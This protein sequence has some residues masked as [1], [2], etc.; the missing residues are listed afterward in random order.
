M[1]ANS[2]HRPLLVAAVALQIGV[3]TAAAVGPAQA[4][5]SLAVLTPELHLGPH[6]SGYEDA[7]VV[8]EIDNKQIL[9]RIWLEKRPP[10]SFQDMGGTVAYSLNQFF[11][12]FKKTNLRS[13]ITNF[14]QRFDEPF[15][16]AWDR[17]KDL[18]RAYPHHAA[19]GNF[20]DKMA[21]LIAQASSK[22]S[23]M[24]VGHPKQSI[25]AKV[26]T[27]TSTSGVSLDVAELKDMVRALLLDKQAS[28]VPAPAPVK[29][30]EQSCVTCGGAYSYRYFR[31]Y[32]VDYDADLESVD[33]REDHCLKTARALIDV[34]VRL[35]VLDA[36]TP[37][38]ADHRKLPCGI[39]SCS[40]DVKPREKKNLFKD[41][42]ALLLGRPFQ[43]KIC[44][45]KTVGKNRAS[46]SDKLDDALW[47]LPTTALQTPW[48]Y[49]SLQVSVR[50][51]M[52]SSEL[53]SSNKA[54]WA[55][56]AYK[57]VDIK[58]AVGDSQKSQ[59][60]ELKELRDHASVNCL[61]YK[62]ENKEKSMTP[63]SETMIARIVKT[64]VLSVLSFIHKS[65]TSSA[66]FWESSIQI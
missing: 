37:W 60:N 29:A 46:W 15:S 30:V 24:V 12:P 58:Y 35:L 42:E 6:Q 50:E 32:G 9:S 63:R 25:V 27:S 4:R 62:E 61:I 26:S 55:L 5:P 1:R 21:P 44:A 65:F 11:P 56:N 52:S 16:E 43:F 3:A 31:F 38:F 40:K 49:S 47:A 18:L 20:L 64:L 8:P 7:S 19:G 53:S 34:H 28:L 23:P 17:F 14:K 66:S 51:G 45:D 13:K 41:V 10:R 33:F 54:Y 39:I 2:H 22:A 59:L 36:S 48:V 57:T